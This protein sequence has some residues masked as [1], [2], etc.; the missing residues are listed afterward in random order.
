MARWARAREP[1]LRRH[2]RAV[3][4]G[5]PR[6]ACRR[7]TAREVAPGSPPPRAPAVDAA[8]QCGRSAGR[9]ATEQRVATMTACLRACSGR[10]FRVLA[11]FVAAG[12]NL[13]SVSHSLRRSLQGGDPL[14]A[15]WL[16][17]DGARA[18]RRRAAAGAL[19]YA[20]ALEPPAPRPSSRSP[21]C[22][23][24]RAS[25]G[26]RAVRRPDAGAAQALA[27]A[28]DPP[29]LDAVSALAGLV[30][31]EWT[32]VVPRDARSTGL[33]FHFD[34]P[35][36][37]AP[38]AI[39]LGGPRRAPTRTWTV[40][41]LA[42]TPSPRR[43]SWRALR[44]VDLARRSAATCCCSAFLPALYFAVNLAATASRTDFTGAR[45]RDAELGHD[46]DAAGAAARAR[47]HATPGCRRARQRPAVAARA[48]VADRR[49]PRRG[50][51]AR[52]CG[53]AAA[54]GAPRRCRAIRRGDAAARAL[55]RARA[56]AR[57]ARRARAARGDRADRRLAAEGGRSFLRLLDRGGAVPAA[58]R[59]AFRWPR[60]SPADPPTRPGRRGWRAAY[61][62]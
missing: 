49:V 53:R 59:R 5:R 43:S 57:G 61:A 21:S 29:R 44:A 47:R 55:R 48:P 16:D 27:V 25:A 6:T 41:T 7:E 52:R 14:P 42:A 17:G 3:L 19:A 45:W 50:R 35:G 46:V 36:A 11:A 30:F 51:A 37:R 20:E 62:R 15:T 28:R 1:L 4:H 2:P 56:A 26:S 24:S 13:A 31:D 58:T 60:P 32:E 9:A 54:A 10:T 33:A 23:T 8:A 39:L 38:Q 18:P 12:R 34:A 22:R 40:E